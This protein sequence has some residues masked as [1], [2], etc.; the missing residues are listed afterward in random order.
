MAMPGAA[1]QLLIEVEDEGADA[2]ELDELA[3][4]LR[5]EL[6]ELDVEAVEQARAGEAP[7]GAKGMD[8]VAMGTL[9]VT[10]ARTPGVVAGLSGLLHDWLSRREG[11][12]V[13]LELEGETL[14]ANRLSKDE[15]QA[16]I[17]AFLR[18]H[19]GG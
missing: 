5:R 2:G 4:A 13:K 9:L 19:G 10:M 3:T 8:A 7:A 12:S 18:R 15:H 1:T 6:L 14:E 11:R 17:A 16:L